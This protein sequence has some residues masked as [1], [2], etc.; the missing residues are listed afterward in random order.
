[1]RFNVIQ[2]NSFCYDLIVE[3]GATEYT[4]MRS[5]DAATNIYATA[6]HCD[7]FSLICHTP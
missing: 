3:I 1:M 5:S 2:T 7:T 6:N 4:T